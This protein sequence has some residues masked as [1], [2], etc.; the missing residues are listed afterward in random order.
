MDFTK[1]EVD[2]LNAVIKVKVTPADYESKVDAALKTYQKKA[3]MPGFRPGKVPSGMIRKMYGKSLLMDEINKLLQENLYKYISENNIEALGNPLPK[4]D[5]DNKIDWDNQKDFEFTYDIGLAPKFKVELSDKDKFTKYV[6]RMDDESINKYTSDICKRY[7]KVATADI[8][9]ENDILFG[10]FVELD[11]AGIIVPGG[12]FKS[13]SLAVER[14]KNEELKKQLIGLKKGDK[15]IVESL[16]LSENI[17]DLAAMLG[18]DKE[19]AAQLK[20]KFQYTVTNISRLAPADM[21]QELFDKVYGKDVVKTAEE[22][23]AKIKEELTAMF[24]ND[25]EK[26]LKN[27]IVE[28]LMKKIA[29]NLPDEFLKR[30]LMEVNEKPLTIEQIAAEYP[31]YSE[32]LKWQLIENKILK[33]HQIKV[34]SDEAIAYVKELVKNHFLEAGQASIDDAEIEKTAQRVLANEEESKKVYNDLY[35][36]KTMKLYTSTFT[37]EEKEV[38]YE[39]FS[40]Q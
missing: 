13:S 27:D 18:I 36:K 12:I 40:K 8:S 17:T 19:K 21:N 30:W 7:G 39:E 29:V 38:S 5:S 35:E 31:S 34:D 10:D 25:S 16:K 6:V 14:M 37:I 2:Q 4:A 20:C 24:E 22:F 3:N 15:I 26:R 9:E 32:M 23:N 33:E 11:E 1:Q 28:A